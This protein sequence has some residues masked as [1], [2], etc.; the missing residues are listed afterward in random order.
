MN[1][2]VKKIRDSEIGA[3]DVL[4]TPVGPRRLLYAD[5]TVPPPETRTTVSRSFRVFE[6]PA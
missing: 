2:L 3:N 1:P 5:Y 4:S 6:L